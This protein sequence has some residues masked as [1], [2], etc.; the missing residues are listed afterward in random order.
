MLLFILFASDVDDD[1]A[2]TPPTFRRAALTVVDNRAA[3]GAELARPSPAAKLAA[4]V[5]RALLA[6]SE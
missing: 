1:G 6:P 2:A 5:D 3:L 4:V